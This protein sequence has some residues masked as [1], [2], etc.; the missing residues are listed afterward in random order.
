MSIATLVH[1]TIKNVPDCNTIVFQKYI[2]QEGGLR[3][4]NI[5]K[6]SLP[7]Q[8]L[9]SVITVVFNGDK[10]VENTIKSIMSQNYRNIEH[11]VIDGGSNDTTVDILKQ[12]NDVI[13]YWVSE[14]DAGIYD[15]MNKG[16]ARATGD[17]V[18]FLN[19]DDT[20]NAVDVVEKIVQTFISKQYEAVFADLIYVKKND[21]NHVVRKYSSKH[22]SPDRLIYG[23]M[24]AH[25]TLY[26]RK[27]IFEKYGLFKK[28]YQIA[29]DYELV[30]RLFY[31]YRISYKY[32]PIEMVKMNI[33]GISTRGWY[34]SI[35][36]N[37]EVLRA[38]RE[39]GIKTNLFKICSKYPKKICEFIFK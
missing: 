26:L 17:I 39:N 22:F 7:E 18:G 25:P 28:D 38:C 6:Q 14:K 11:I 13:D 23:W 33:G 10:T 1:D 32:L 21:L 16:I 20:Y 24:P 9:I 35:L 5:Y 29:G 2:K 12:Y 30:A 19:A 37:K 34:N 15:A 4:E 8:P 31:K 27:E 3:L 36:L